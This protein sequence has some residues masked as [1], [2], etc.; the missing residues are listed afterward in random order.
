[1]TFSS[2]ETTIAPCDFKNFNVG[3]P[4]TPAPK[5]MHLAPLRESIKL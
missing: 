3:A 2:T 4:V 5:R 1:M